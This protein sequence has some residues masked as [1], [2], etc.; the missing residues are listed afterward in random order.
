MSRSMTL[1]HGYL[2]CPITF[3]LGPS[4]IAP[5][6]KPKGKATLHRVVRSD[7]LNYFGEDL[8]CP[9]ISR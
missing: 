2:S 6:Q 4:P 7:H 3:L 9:R 8:T 1:T 5:P